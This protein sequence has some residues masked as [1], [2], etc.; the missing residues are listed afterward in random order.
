M[1]MSVDLNMKEFDDPYEAPSSD[2]HRNEAKLL[3]ES[4]PKISEVPS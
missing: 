4:S 1:S 2:V 3:L